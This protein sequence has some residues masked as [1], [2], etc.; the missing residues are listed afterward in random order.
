LNWK[1]IIFNQV[2]MQKQKSTYLHPL[3]HASCHPEG[4]CQ[5]STCAKGKQKELSLGRK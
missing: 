3:P 5:K 1:N 2:V 4:E